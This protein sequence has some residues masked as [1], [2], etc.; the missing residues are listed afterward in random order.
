MLRSRYE[1]LI[2]TGRL[3]VY[4]DGGLIM[5]A[6]TPDGP[7]GELDL[8]VRLRGALTELKLTLDPDRYL[9]V[10]RLD[11]HDLQRLTD[12]SV[13]DEH[14]N[15][16]ERLKHRLRGPARGIF[17][18]DVASEALVTHAQLGGSPV[19]GRLL[20]IEDRDLGP[21]LG[22]QP[23]RGHADAARA[24]RPRDDGDSSCHKHGASPCFM[25]KHVNPNSAP[26]PDKAGAEPRVCRMGKPSQQA[27]HVGN[28][29]GPH[30]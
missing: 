10:L 27:S 3:S 20:Q 25:P 13:L 19:R 7:A 6:G 9:V 5:K 23:C 17:L 24:R 22:E 1:K 28:T 16:A 8:A 15:L 30:V 26:H 4:G 2:W 21:V 18:R 11:L 14:I 12:T 29:N